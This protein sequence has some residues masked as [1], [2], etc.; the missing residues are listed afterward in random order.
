MT[1][2]EFRDRFGIPIPDDKLHDIPFYK[3]AEDAPEM[4]YLHER[5]TA[6]G[7]Y[8]PARRMKADEQLKVPAWMCLPR[9]W[10]QR[11]RAVRSR[12]RRPMSVA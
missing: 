5:R 12:P 1:I 10:K 7:G 8:L 11:Q 9:R 2:H 6:L 4:K 3:P